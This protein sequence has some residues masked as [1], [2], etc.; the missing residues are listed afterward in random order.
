MSDVHDVAPNDEVAS[1]TSSMVAESGKSDIDEPSS[2][3]PTNEGESSSTSQPDL[4]VIRAPRIVTIHVAGELRLIGILDPLDRALG[5]YF[6]NPHDEVLVR[7][8]MAHSNLAVQAVV[9]QGERSVGNHVARKLPS[10][11]P[12]RAVREFHFNLPFRVASP[13]AFRQLKLPLGFRRCFLGLKPS[14]TVVHKLARDADCPPK[15]VKRYNRI[16]QAWKDKNG[17]LPDR[18]C[19]VA[20]MAWPRMAHCAG[21]MSLEFVQELEADSLGGTNVVM[22]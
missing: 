21:G 18:Q 3:T 10:L 1:N 22:W 7:N 13:A 9:F 19:D 2:T 8:V 12:G 14:G 11:Y 15:L 16:F 4:T 20:L 5:Y 17:A 6:D